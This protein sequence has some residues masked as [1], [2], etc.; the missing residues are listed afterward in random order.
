MNQLSSY[1][2]TLNRPLKTNQIMKVYK[3]ISKNGCD[4]YLHQNQLIADAGHLPKL[5]SFFLFM[6]KEESFVMIIDGECVDDVY[7]E[8]KGEWQDHI[9]ES[10][11][12]R[13]YN[14]DMV[15]NET[16]ILV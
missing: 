8:I 3:T 4:L 13:K 12:R 6:N 2:I 11:C 14:E 5:L 16:S 10:T 7:D 1:Q 9:A 15:E